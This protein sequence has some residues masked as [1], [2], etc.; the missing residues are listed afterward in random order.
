MISEF[1]IFGCGN[2]GKLALDAIGEDNCK[3]FID[4]DSKYAYSVKYGKN[5][6]PFDIAK[7]EGLFEKF[8]VVVGVSEHTAM[9]IAE[10]LINNHINKFVFL[11]ELEL[12][13]ELSELEITVLHL[14]KLTD[15]YRTKNQLTEKKLNFI[16]NNIDVRSINTCKGYYRKRQ[17]DKLKFAVDFLEELKDIQVIP[18]LICGNLLGKFRHNGFIPW[19]DDIDFGVMRDEYDKLIAYCQSK[20]RVAIYEGLVCDVNAQMKFE[21][22]EISKQQGIVLIIFPEHIQLNYGDSLINRVC[23]DF[24]CFDRFDD[25][26]FSVYQQLLTETEN[27]IKD[28]KTASEKNLIIKTQL[29]K[30]N[31]FINSEGKNIYFSIDSCLAFIGENEEWIPSDVI[32]P[33]QEI[34][35]EGYKLS[36]PADIEKYLKYEYKDY[37]NIPSD[38]GVS[39]H[40]YVNDYFSHNF[41]SVEF[42][43]TNIEEI[44]LFMPVYEQLRNRGIYARYILEDENINIAGKEINYDLVNKALQNFELEYVEFCNI[45]ADFAITTND[46]KVLGEYRCAKKIKIEKN[47]GDISLNNLYTGFDYVCESIDE[48]INLVIGNEDK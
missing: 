37:M 43:I 14:E 29:C 7:K 22:D 32:F 27:L 12:I 8:W 13:N 45:D 18:F 26:D 15:Y 28:V 4:N 3:C 34:E 35:Y 36:A 47:K 33:L 17:M 40:D 46:A 31:K 16:R 1:M 41:I 42:Y 24:F 9:C 11:D 30:A 2:Y 20:Y 21:S 10:Q 25:V 48:C 44:E 38:C 23:V 19:D 6:I 5:V 39:N